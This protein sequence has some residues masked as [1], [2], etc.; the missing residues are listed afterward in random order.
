MSK[1]FIS[2]ISIYNSYNGAEPY[3]S[4]SVNSGDSL[5]TMT[6]KLSKE[7]CE[8]LF[9]HLYRLVEKEKEKMASAIM[10]LSLQPL[11]AA[12]HT[13]PSI[14]LNDEIPF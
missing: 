10:D 12:P 6:I 3:G 4:F 5:S 13:G 11:L 9:T 8:A 14:D 2:S 7:D 1:G